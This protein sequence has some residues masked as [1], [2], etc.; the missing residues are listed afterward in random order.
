MKFYRQVNIKYLIEG[1]D[2][3]PFKITKEYIDDIFKDYPK[4]EIVKIHD[5]PK[6]GL[7]NGLFATGAGIGGITIIQTIEAFRLLLHILNLN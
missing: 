4:H 1:N 2:I 5:K 3:L 6:V 7:V